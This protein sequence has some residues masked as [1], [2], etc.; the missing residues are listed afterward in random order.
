[1]AFSQYFEHHEVE[2]EI[3]RRW[4]KSGAFQPSQDT[5]KAPFTISM[6]PPNA[7]GT[8]H[9]GHAIGMTVEDLM[10]RW[11][12]MQGH[13]ALWVPGTDHAA[14]ATE[15]VV[16]RNLQSEGMDDPRHQLGREELVARI[17]AFTE[18]SRSTIRS[19]IRALGASCDWTRERYTMEPALNRVVNSV[20]SRMFRDGLI[21]RAPRIVNWDPH[22]RTTVSDDEIYYS[23]RE[24]KF[25]TLRYG[26]FLVGTSRPETKLGDTAVAVHPEDERYREHIGKTYE[27]P[28]PKGPTITV[29]VVA[30]EHVDPEY[31]T[32][33][34]GVTPAHSHADFEIA[35]KHNLPLIQVIGEDGRMT[36]AAGPYAGK[37]VEEAR[38]AFVADLE[39]AGLMEKIESYAQPVSLCYRSKLPI[40]PLPKNQWF[41]DVNKPAV[42]WEGRNMTLKQVMYE[43]VDSG[44]IRL[45]PEHEVKTYN[46]WIENLRDWCISRQIWWGHRVPVWYRG[47]AVSEDNIEAA[48]EMY[49]GHRRPDGEGW[50]QDPDTLDTW[51]SSALWTFST[52]LDSEKALDDDLD[53][54]EIIARSPDFERFH[55]TSVMETGYDILFF[56]VARMILMT[57]Y[58]VKDIPF[59]TVYLHGLVLD[60]DGEKMSKSKPETSIDP[61]EVIEEYGAD[62]LR[63]SLVL[64][65]SA[66]SDLKLG[67]ERIVA[68]KR[69]LNKIWNAAKLVEM[70]SEGK[71]RLELTPASVV[72]PLNRWMLT[73]RNV[74]L[75]RINR[76]M[77][78]FAFGDAAEQ[79]RSAFW[80]EF[81]DF[82]LE[83]IKVD[84]V[85]ESPETASVLSNVLDDFLK[86]LHPFLPFLTEQVWSNLGREGLLISADWPEPDES[87]SWK[88][89]SEGVDAVSRAVAAVRSLRAEQNIDPGAY[90]NVRLQPRRHAEV[91][92]TCRPILERLM[93]TEELVISESEEETKGSLAVDEAF[94]AALTLSAAD[95]QAERERFEKQLE[96]AQKRLASL[97]SRLK[98]E[99][100][101][102]NAPKETIESTRQSA[103]K[104]KSTIQDI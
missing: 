65:N 104:T 94:R 93:R 23:D 101:L 39:A 44:K 2:S 38:E 85:A 13:P 19:Q 69:L 73:R 71:K 47:N 52:L 41:I 72:H 64:G 31:G 81:C 15:S 82:Y 63:L 80:G 95:L 88:D 103:Q 92:E 9:L 37:E 40:E 14:I 32:G 18:D 45:L 74:L 79:I 56:W 89:E 7:T 17:A 78:A 77:E 46:H 8:L 29:K 11:K 91:F 60:K 86:L 61:L 5:G 21:Y 62:A 90:V 35:Q 34:L 20:F 99:G 75:E 28:W 96:G 22:L 55:P 70:S 26:P 33:A 25:Y 36:E 66:G 3:Y 83:A 76:R 98:N 49:V 51:F 97:E 102:N 53:L 27:V 48:E 24:A 1:M 16:I 100:F 68:C 6:P 58:T 43:V 87:L 30:D 67:Q 10:I 57:T 59:S 12:R 54:D 42:Q 84:E 50:V 4:D